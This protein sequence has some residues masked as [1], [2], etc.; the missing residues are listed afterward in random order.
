MTKTLIWPKNRNRSCPSPRLQGRG[1]F[2]LIELTVVIVVISLLFLAA[3][4]R[5]LYW[6]ERAEKAAMESVLAAV[7]MGLQIRAAELMMSNRPSAV[8]ALQIENPMR[9][10]DQPPS[11]YAGDMDV[12]AKP[13][14]W[15]YDAKDHE[16][17]Y[18]PK[19]NS[20][21]ETGQSAS[22]ELRFRVTVLR[23]ANAADGGGM[24]VR[25]SVLPVR[26]YKWF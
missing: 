8:A 11:N 19:S 2:T 5:F 12:A 10:L 15:Y 17:V 14:Y 16:L 9:W 22:K 3:A 23:E 26:E 20:Y 6:E 21:L 13:A 1:G 4:E 25:V 7:K 18:S 24:L